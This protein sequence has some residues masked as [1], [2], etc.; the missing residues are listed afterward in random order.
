[1]NYS[2][3]P[4]EY[5]GAFITIDVAEEEIVTKEV[6]ITAAP[7][8]MLNGGRV[9]F[10]A[11]VLNDST[12]T[13]PMSLSL[14]IDK[15]PISTMTAFIPN[16]IAELQ[17]YLNGKTSMTGSFEKPIFTGEVAAE[18]GATY[19]RTLTWPLSAPTSS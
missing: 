14:D 9:A 10:A 16:G 5:G 17:G 13:S 3:T 11:G 4:T 1:M 8:F 2:N 19:V 15:F 12:A 18:D 7:K 6:V